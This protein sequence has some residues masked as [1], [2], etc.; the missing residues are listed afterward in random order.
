MER[1]KR[2]WGLRLWSKTNLTF[3]KGFEQLNEFRAAQNI[4]C[5]FLRISLRIRGLEGLTMPNYSRFYVKKMTLTGTMH[6]FQ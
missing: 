4:P 3:G 5:R 6:S 2:Q 1:E